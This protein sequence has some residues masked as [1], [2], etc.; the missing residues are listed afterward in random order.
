MAILKRDF[1]T[2]AAETY[3]NF[4]SSFKGTKISLKLVKISLYILFKVNF[5]YKSSS[6]KSYLVKSYSLKSFDKMLTTD[7]PEKKNFTKHKVIF[8]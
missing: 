7:E 6:V 5:D 8:S 4:D 1:T 2:I 3:F